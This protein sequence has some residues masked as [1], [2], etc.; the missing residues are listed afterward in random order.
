MFSIA[1]WLR[2]ESA[3]GKYILA[4]PTD[5]GAMTNEESG[6][7]FLDNSGPSVAK[8]LNLPTLPSG[9]KYEGWIVI[10]GIP[11]STGT[12]IDANT[13]DSNAASSNFKGT[14]GNGPNYPGEDLLR[15][16]PTG[17]TFPTDLRGKIVAISI[18][19]S[20]DNGTECLLSY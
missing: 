6:I 18:E 8:G 7:W 13:A 17:L 1:Q 20:T 12:F 9:W 16:A 3:S 15:N 4:T 11:V 10:N 19:P 14:I 5:G 2:I